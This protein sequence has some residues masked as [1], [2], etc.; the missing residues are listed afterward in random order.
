MDLDNSAVIAGG[1]RLGWGDLEEGIERI[2]G[3]GENNNKREKNVGMPKKK[4]PIQKLK[5][6]G[7]KEQRQPQA[8][9]VATYP[10]FLRFRSFFL[11]SSPSL[12]STL[13]FHCCQRV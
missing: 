5:N 11:S 1:G 7:A 8:A 3:E 4:L 12:V 2:N 10:L 9:C 13:L 6:V